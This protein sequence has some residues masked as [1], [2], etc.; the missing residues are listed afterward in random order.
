VP[1][2]SWL[3]AA[4]TGEERTVD[5]TVVPTYGAP[6][7][8]AIITH[9]QGFFR[10]FVDQR[11]AKALTTLVKLGLL[12]GADVPAVANQPRTANVALGNPKTPSTTWD[13]LCTEIE[14]ELADYVT[15]A[16]PTKI[17]CYAR[18]YKRTSAAADWEKTV[19]RHHTLLNHP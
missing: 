8:G 16:F 19:Q 14:Q 6:G 9:A 4:P 2:W 5:Y 12:D 3:N 18:L 1:L 7:P 17:D 13:A 10:D 11:N 15:A